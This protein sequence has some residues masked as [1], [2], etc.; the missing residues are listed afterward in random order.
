MRFRPVHA[1]LPSLLSENPAFRRFWLALLVSSTG[2]RFGS[3]AMS[4]YVL[5]VT[6]SGS[7][8]AGMLAVQSLPSLFIAPLAGVWIDRLSRRRV[9]LLGNFASALIY[10]LLPFA[11]ELWQLYALAL[12][13][14][15]AAT[16]LLPAQRALVPDLVEARQVVQANA[17]I[18][19]GQ[20][21]LLLVS[22]SLA[23]LLV[24]FA[25]ASAAFAVNAFTYLAANG[26]LLGIR[27]ELPRTTA[28]SRSVGQFLRELQ[29]GFSFGLRHPGLRIVL[30]A[31]FCTAIAGAMLG[32]MEVILISETLGGGDSGYGYMLSLVGLGAIVASLAAPRMDRRFSLPS[33]YIIGIVGSGLG[34]FVYANAGLLWLA[35]LAAGL[36][37]V[38]WFLRQIVIDSIVQQWAPPDLRGRIFAILQMDRPLGLLLFTGLFAAYIDQWGPVVLLN[39]AGVIYT[40][41]ALWVLSQIGTLRRMRA[42]SARR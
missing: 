25:G 7:A 6:G 5:K 41:V 23:G 8:L 30:I 40:A 35:I 10:G 16:F 28:N 18:S 2:D 32:T 37:A 27:G 13:A 24:G 19:A 15:C 14:R 42:W 12:L 39:L 33:L 4:L 3:I 29:D 21:T 20:Q 34:F 26:L 22:A 1:Y 17:T 31:T 36:H 9:L 38:P 11:Q